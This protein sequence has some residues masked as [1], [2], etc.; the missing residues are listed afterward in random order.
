MRKYGFPLPCIF[1]FSR[2]L[3]LYG[4]KWVNE[5]PYSRIFV[6]T[7]LIFDC[8]SNK[9][10]ISYSGI[11][12][13]TCVCQTASANPHNAAPRKNTY[14][15][16]SEG[17]QNRNEI[18]SP[19]LIAAPVNIII[20]RPVNHSTIFPRNREK[21][22]STAPKHIIMRPTFSIPRAHVIKD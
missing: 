9:C 19:I 15:V 14:K 22:A 17:F 20:G 5:N 4:K 7:L 11:L 2:I 3:S 13:L 10:A 16:S 21:N 1:L 6:A 18:S 12:P 8:K